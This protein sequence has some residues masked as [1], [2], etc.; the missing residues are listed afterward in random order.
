MERATEDL[1][2]DYPRYEAEFFRYF[3]DLI[4]YVA[5]IKGDGSQKNNYQ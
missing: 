3:P 2:R 1:R 5:E 4:R